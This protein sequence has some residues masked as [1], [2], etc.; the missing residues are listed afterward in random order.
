VVCLSFSSVHPHRLVIGLHIRPG[1]HGIK[2]LQLTHTLLMA[3]TRPSGHSV[4]GMQ[5]GEVVL[6]VAAGVV[7]GTVV[8]LGA[9]VVLGAVAD[10]GAKVVI[11]VATHSPH[12]R[13]QFC[14]IR[15]WVWQ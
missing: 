7:L 15:E 9:G 10:V 2:I 3:H 6:S 14:L 11:T 12:V 1:A 4:R 5:P 8:V 13:L